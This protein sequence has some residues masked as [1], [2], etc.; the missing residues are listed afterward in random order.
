MADF[1][2]RCILKTIFT[3][4]TPKIDD[5]VLLWCLLLDLDQADLTDFEGISQSPTIFYRRLS[6]DF[7]PNLYQKLTKVEDKLLEN[8]LTID[9]VCINLKKP[10]LCDSRYRIRSYKKQENGQNIM[11]YIDA[12][13]LLQLTRAWHIHNYPK[14][15]VE[16]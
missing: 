7:D 4:D 1:C 12:S 10:G 5:R 14:G 3:F 9:E 16:Y 11:L 6:S 13:K 2:K 8:T 15:Q